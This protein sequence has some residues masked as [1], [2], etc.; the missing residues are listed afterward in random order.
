MHTMANLRTLAN[1][2]KSHNSE[3]SSSNNLHSY[4]RENR[5]SSD[6]IW[7]GR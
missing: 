4:R 7:R 3:I 2:A 1:S 5:H 6:I